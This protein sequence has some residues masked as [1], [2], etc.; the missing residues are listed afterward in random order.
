MEEEHPNEEEVHGLEN[1]GSAPFLTRATYEE[2]LSNGTSCEFIVATEQQADQQQHSVA[3]PTSLQEF[4]PKA[5]SSSHGYE[6]LH[7]F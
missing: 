6:D 2:A 5:S 1:K 3:G 4:V 7:I